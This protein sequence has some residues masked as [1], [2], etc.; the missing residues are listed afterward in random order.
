MDRLVAALRSHSEDHFKI[1]KDRQD[2]MLE[3]LD[4]RQACQNEALKARE[5]TLFK[6]IIGNFGSRMDYMSRCFD[7]RINTCMDRFDRLEGALDGF[8]KT[9]AYY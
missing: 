2:E 3:L 6:D 5:D 8:M 1:L 4:D 7:Y 9:V